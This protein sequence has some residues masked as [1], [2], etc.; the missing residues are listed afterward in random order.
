MSTCKTFV[1]QLKFCMHTFRTANSYT[2]MTTSP[3]DHWLRDKLHCCILQVMHT[4]QCNGSQSPGTQLSEPVKLLTARLSILG[5]WSG[6]EEFRRVGGMVRTGSRGC[7]GTLTRSLRIRDTIQEDTNEPL[8]WVLIHRVYV[9]HICHTEEENLC[10]NCHRDVFTPHFINILLCL[11]RYYHF[12]LN[13][14]N[15]FINS[16]YLKL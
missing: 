9:S 1:M 15:H 8:E 4:N 7:R 14:E 16:G 2:T 10:V 13:M 6:V 3:H 12:G 11:L 5:A